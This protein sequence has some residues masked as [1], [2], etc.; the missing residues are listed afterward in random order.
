VYTEARMA[1][2]V[3]NVEIVN[4]NNLEREINETRR[5]RPANCENEKGVDGIS[6]AP[7]E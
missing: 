7:D 6:V 4:K 1:H 2:S 5:S 3:Q